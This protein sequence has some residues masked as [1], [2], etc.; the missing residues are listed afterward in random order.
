MSVEHVIRAAGDVDHGIKSPWSCKSNLLQ[1]LE[2]YWEKWVVD[3]RSFYTATFNN[4][5][6]CRG[7]VGLI[8]LNPK[9]SNQSHLN[10]ESELH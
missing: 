1:C 10:S 6:L 5:L 9:I 7:P 4:S 3:N 8:Y 2:V